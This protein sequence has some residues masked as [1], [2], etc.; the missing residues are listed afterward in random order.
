MRSY[1]DFDLGWMVGNFDGEGYVVQRRPDSKTRNFRPSLR[2]TSTDEDTIDRW[3]SL[4]GGKKQGPY[5]PTNPAHKSFWYWALSGDAAVDLAKQML[6][7][8]C[9]RRRDQLKPLIDYVP[10]KTGRPAKDHET[11]CSKEDCEAPT[12]AR[13]LC[14]KHYQ[15]LTRGK[16]R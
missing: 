10:R 8:L 13:T 9:L 11:P 4:A 6:P 16:L 12:V 2:L 3:F 14:S 15:R 1:T 7:Y 5:R